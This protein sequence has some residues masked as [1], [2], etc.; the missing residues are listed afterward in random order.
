MGPFVSPMWFLLTLITLSIATP[1]VYL[2][3]RYFKQ[4]GLVVLGIFAWTGIWFTNFAFEINAVFY[5]TL[6]A[7]LSINKKNMII[8]FKRFRLICYIGFIMMLLVRTCY[9][10]RY[11]YDI[12]SFPCVFLGVGS[13]INFAA[14]LLEHEKTKVNLLLSKS[15]FFIYGL[16]TIFIIFFVGTVFDIIFK[17]QNTLLLTIRYFFVPIITVYCCVFIFWIMKKTMP[18]LLAVLAGGRI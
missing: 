11:A 9:Y 12:L 2:W 3:C 6:G 10:N 17:K 14:Y 4:Y 18:K 5:F 15:S 13:A 7:Y 1:I 8:E 16:H